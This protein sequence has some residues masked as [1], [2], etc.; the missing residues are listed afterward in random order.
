MEALASRP[1]SAPRGELPALRMR[2]PHPAPINFSHSEIFCLLHSPFEPSPT[3]CQPEDSKVPDIGRAP[4]LEA[5]DVCPLKIH[6][7]SQKPPKRLPCRSF[8]GCYLHVNHAVISLDHHQ[9][10]KGA[11][12]ARLRLVAGARNR[13]D[14]QLRGLLATVIGP[15]GSVQYRAFRLPLVGNKR[16]C[17]LRRADGR[18]LSTVRPLSSECLGSDLN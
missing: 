5:A 7:L 14:L 8:I 13:L 4:T 1:T 15:W 9:Y 12:K 2:T 3:Y 18:L 6:P 10:D 16:S 17:H 11:E